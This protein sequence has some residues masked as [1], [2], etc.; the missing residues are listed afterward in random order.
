[1]ASCLDPAGRL[2]VDTVF[3]KEEAL[4]LQGS[5]TGRGQRK[6]KLLCG[7]WPLGVARRTYRPS[8][9]GVD[10]QGLRVS[11]QLYDESEASLGYTN[12]QSKHGSA[13]LSSRSR[14]YLKK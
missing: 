3:S 13:K 4:Q 11:G 7:R 6:R 14:F 10:T 5:K 2:R 8:A 1:M 12:E 9:L